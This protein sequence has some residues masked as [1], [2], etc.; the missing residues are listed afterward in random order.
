[1]I[2]TKF[3]MKIMPLEATPA[4]YFLISYTSAT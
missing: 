3:G 2:F 1:M 4:S